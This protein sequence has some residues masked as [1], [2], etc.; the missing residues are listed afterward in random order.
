MDALP[1]Y[2]RAGTDRPG[3]ATSPVNRIA[4]NAGPHFSHYDEERT[5]A[6]TAGVSVTTDW[7]LELGV[8][9]ARRGP[10]A[11]IVSS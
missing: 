8:G 1:I 5:R 4:V 2:N 7:G 3:G 10:S 11:Q 9:Y 6:M